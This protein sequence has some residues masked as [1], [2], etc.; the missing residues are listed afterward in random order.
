M[1]EFNPYAA[2]VTDLSTPRA[3]D[4]TGVWRDGVLLV[5]SKGAELPDRCL[6]C[7]EPANGWSLKRN[8]SWHP[9]WYY[10]LFLISPI[11]YIIVA[12]IVRKT[13][14]TRIP[15]CPRHRGR[16][17]RIIALAWTLSLV[18][19]LVL[20]AGAVGSDSVKGFAG[21][22]AS[23]AVLMISIFGGLAMFLAGLI[24]AVIAS[25]VVVP[26]KIDKRFVWLKKVSPDL[27]ASLPGWNT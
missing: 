13:A 2:P 18:G 14:K 7:N 22:T 10:L 17:R 25:Q 6:K 20:F 8:L 16:R 27:L 5:M 4:E 9:Q 24:L 23:S 19:P 3:P 11:L 21:E 1:K 15:L 12:L 26:Q